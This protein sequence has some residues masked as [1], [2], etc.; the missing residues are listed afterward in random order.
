M[1]LVTTMAMSGGFTLQCIA[2]ATFTGVREQ[3]PS[4]KWVGSGYCFTLVL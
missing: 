2:I 3:G 4:V 1:G